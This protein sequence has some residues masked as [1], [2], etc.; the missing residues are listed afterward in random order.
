MSITVTKS[1]LEKSGLKGS[2]LDMIVFSSQLPEYTAPPSSIHIHHAI[3]GKSEC[4]CLDMNANCAGMSIAYEQAC[5]YMSVSENINK[6]LIVGCDYIN[7]TINPENELTYGHYGDAACALILEKTHEECGLIDSA[8]SV[9]SV[10]HNNILFPGCGFSKMFK[11]KDI[12]DLKLTF[13]PFE[14]VWLE[15]A[16]KNINKILQKNKIDISEVKMFCLS[17]YV[18][19]NIEVIRSLLGI[20][21]PHSIYIGG[22]YGYTGTSSPFIA[23]YESIARNLVKKGEYVVIWTVGAGTENIA[24]LLKI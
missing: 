22:E 15:T 3:E 16:A 5:K 7:M 8:Y 12:N 10:E 18:Y 4:V 1:A 14:S 21:E 23:L 2:D 17:Q 24:I 19:R 11:A 13:T 9:N 20:D 6:V